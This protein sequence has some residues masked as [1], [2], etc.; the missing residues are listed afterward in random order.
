MSYKRKALA[1][2]KHAIK[3]RRTYRRLGRNLRSKFKKRRSIRSKSYRRGNRGITR[4]RLGAPPQR[5]S[6]GSASLELINNTLHQVAHVGRLASWSVPEATVNGVVVPAASGY[7]KAERFDL[8]G[9]P[10]ITSV[11]YKYLRV[12]GFIE[13]TDKNPMGY[14]MLL[15]EDLYRSQPNWPKK[16]QVFSTD[17]ESPPDIKTLIP[18]MDFFKGDTPLHPFDFSSVIG[19]RKFQ[20]AIGPRYRTLWSMRGKLGPTKTVP[21]E[22]PATTTNVNPL[23][24]TRTASMQTPGLSM[25]KSF[26]KNIPIP[27][28]L[29]YNH[30]KSEP[31]NRNIQL[32][33]FACPL[34]LDSNIHTNSTTYKGIKHNIRCTDFFT[35]ETHTNMEP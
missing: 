29:T 15:L 14:R 31:R 16:I 6:S 30:G 28:Q 10:M 9:S 7:R 24:A 35:A 3:H 13:N 2:I 33:I 18:E 5:Y 23:P 8:N 22:L 20:A 17:E 4:R 32:F 34:T 21:L 27:C 19:L 11:N 25:I 1:V 26:T 12:E